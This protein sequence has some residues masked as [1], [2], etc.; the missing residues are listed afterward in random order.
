M[1]YFKLNKVFLVN[2]VFV[3][4]FDNIITLNN[5]AVEC[6]YLGLYFISFVYSF[7]YVKLRVYF[8]LLQFALIKN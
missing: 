1:K 2:K 8:D 5:T 7:I 4:T 6:E 3:L